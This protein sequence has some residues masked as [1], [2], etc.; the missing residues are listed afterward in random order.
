MIIWLVVKKPFWKMMEF[1]NG[2]AY[3]F[4][5]MEKKTMFEIPPTRWWMITHR[6]HGAAI[7]GA[8]WI[9]SIYP[10]HVSINI[11]APAGSVMGYGWSVPPVQ[12][13]ADYG[14]L[15]NGLGKGRQQQALALETRRPKPWG[16]HVESKMWVLANTILNSTRKY[17]KWMV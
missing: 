11:P 13:K 12:V 1:V 14:D 17:Q 4:F 9:P 3:P 6:I 7:Y 2:K 10:S 15:Q 5:I 16:F 8:P